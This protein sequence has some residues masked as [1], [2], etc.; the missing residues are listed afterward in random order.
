MEIKRELIK[1]AVLGSIKE[2]SLS[3]LNIHKKIDIAVTISDA[4]LFSI[5]Q[6]LIEENFISSFQVRELDRMKKE[7]QITSLGKMRL[8]QFNREYQ[9]VNE[10]HSF[11]GGC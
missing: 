11:V 4:S 7:Y 2:K 1:M 9:M 6:S 3:A 8:D 10:I 5:L